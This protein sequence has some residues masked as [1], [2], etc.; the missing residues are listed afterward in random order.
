MIL[1]YELPDCKEGRFLGLKGP[2]NSESMLANPISKTSATRLLEIW[3]EGAAGYRKCLNNQ[4]L[5][6]LCF[7]FLINFHFGIILDL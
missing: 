1:C 2:C 6:L 3:K 5:I 7:A 4:A